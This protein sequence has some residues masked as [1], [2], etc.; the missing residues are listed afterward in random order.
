[1]NDVIVD[2]AGQ[3]D[4]PGLVE[5]AALTFPDACPPNATT[6]DITEHLQHHLN[7]DVFRSWIDDPDWTVLVARGDDGA[8]LGYFVLSARPDEIDR[9]VTAAVNKDFQGWELSKCYTLRQARGRGVADK[10]MAAALETARQ[11]GASGLW[12]GVN[13]ENQRAQAFYRSHGFREV[14]P[15]E[16]L[17]GSQ[18]HSD[19]LMERA[20]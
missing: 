8:L 10:L 16:Y 9:F 3:S 7:A 17:V 18:V 15:R 5:L 19:F 1:V 20:L 2:E 13:A 14:G 11:R 12:L 4:V 6:A